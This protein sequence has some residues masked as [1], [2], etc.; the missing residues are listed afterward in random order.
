[1]RKKVKDLVE[2]GIN[3]EGKSI[4]KRIDEYRKQIEN[5]LQK[6]NIYIAYNGTLSNTEPTINVDDPET[7]IIIAFEANP[8]YENFH[9]ISSYKLSQEAFDEF[10]KTDNIDLSREQKL[11]LAN[12]EKYKKAAKIYS[13]FYL[14]A[15]KYIKLC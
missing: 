9:F 4:V 6:S 15:M 14:L 10:V 12:T 5:V 2:F 1:M 8:M 13:V 7:R 3:V 11:Q